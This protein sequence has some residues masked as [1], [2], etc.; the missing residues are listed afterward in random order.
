MSHSSI[1]KEF[2]FE[3][4]LPRREVKVRKVDCTENMFDDVLTMLQYDQLDF[5]KYENLTAR[6]VS[7]TFS[8]MFH[9]FKKGIFVSINDGKLEAF[10][11]FDNIDY[12]NE[13]SHLLRIDAAKYANIQA[14]IDST[15]AI[16]GFT[17]TQ[18]HKPVQEWYANDAMFRYDGTSENETNVAILSDM[19]TALCMERDIPD[20]ELF[21]NK[22]DFPLLKT[23]DTEPYENLFGT[24]FQKLM[25][26]SYD[27]YSPILSGSIAGAFADILVPTHEDWA[28]AKY[29]ALGVTL[30]TSYREYPKIV[31]KVPWSAKKEIAVFRGSSTG[32][33]VTAKT[34]QRLRALELSSKYPKHLDAGITK[35]NTRIRK[36]AS[37]K[38]LETIVRTNYP[39]VA[40]MTLQEQTDAYKYILTLEGH[41]AAYRLSYELSSNSLVLLA[42]SRWKLWFSHFLKPNVHYIPVKEDLSDLIEKIEWCRNN[43]DR[44]RKIVENANRFYDEYLGTKGILDFLQRTLIDL[45]MNIGGYSWLPNLVNLSIAEE[46]ALLFTPEKDSIQ[47]LPYAHQVANGPRCIGK[48]VATDKVLKKTGTLD[49]VRN[50]VTG[51]HCK[52]DCMKTNGFLVAKKTVS[53]VSKQNRQIHEAYIG[54][55]A[56]NKILR[57]CPNFAYVYEPK[58]TETST[59]TFMEF[60][61]G[62]LL[63]QWI[64]SELYNEKDLINIMCSVNLALAVAQTQCGFVH[65]D[66]TPSNIIIQTTSSPVTFDYNTGGSPPLRYTSRIV[67]VIIDYGKSR[68]VVY[69]QKY[70]LVDRGYI[71]LYRSRTKS[72]D[73]LTLIYTTIDVLVK[74]KRA[75][76]KIILDLQKYFSLPRIL[77]DIVT[78]VN[79]SEASHINPLTFINYIS[80][81]VQLE[82]VKPG[83]FKQKMNRGN[84]FI[85]EML[86]K[87]G[88]TK[89]AVKE[90][91]SRLYRQAV[92][93]SDNTVVTEIINTLAAPHLLA[94]D[95]YVSSLADPV[96]TGNYKRIK[97]TLLRES[98]VTSTT[99]LMDFPNVAYLR[100]DA[101]LTPE[102]LREFAKE[103]VK[104]EGDWITINSECLL[105]ST[106]NSKLDIFG[107]LGNPA[108]DNFN[109]LNELASENT[110]LWIQNAVA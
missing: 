62:P 104:T 87:H 36:H 61:S 32:A 42:G 50:I 99:L 22:R 7:N 44:C 1:T 53:S 81:H 107:I 49:Y 58:R 102:E 72:L 96:V 74:E 100:M 28:R 67:P 16:L 39:K 35:W 54:R 48:L 69:E 80:P 52:V 90:A 26:H 78:F 31:E 60:I 8:Y 59:E 63:S 94:L 33:G 105:V 68:A 71:N 101:Y 21:V 43:D 46:A 37:S 9:K 77:K 73:T 10:V 66:L 3:E 34:N 18:K 12:M 64:G 41:V 24:K 6:A 14:L 92:L 13:W 83:E 88:D 15:S 82:V 20:I 91:V 11:S 76:P 57:E 84:A 23:N 93:S 103:A 29:Q 56:I 17:P 109:Y 89:L 25:S 98:P 30:P 95:E 85:E 19:F 106:L 79:S 97:Q 5:D 45:A 65:H 55:N 70:G 2:Q 38:F 110:I 47:G 40:P 86:M 51:K 4:L 108:F 75:V 27:Q